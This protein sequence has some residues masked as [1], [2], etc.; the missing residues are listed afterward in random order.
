MRTA[1]ITVDPAATK[2]STFRNYCDLIRLFQS[3]GLFKKSSVVA[4]IHPSL[5]PTPISWYQK[6]KTKLAKDALESLQNSCRGKFQF[7]AVKVLRSDTHDQES[8]VRQ[9]SNFGRAN[10][11]DVLVISSHNRKG[12]PYWVLGSFAETASLTSA[13][14]VLI[15]KPH[16]K[17]KDFS[18]EVRMVVCI[19]V[20]VPISQPDLN[21]ILSSARDANAHVDWVYIEPS[22]IPLLETLQQAKEKPEAEK[23]LGGLRSAAAKKGIKSSVKVLQEYTSIAHTL[24]DY[25]D[26]RKAWLTITLSTR[27][28]RARRLWLGSTGRQVLKLTKRPFLNL[29]WE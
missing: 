8:L 18:S 27:R 17:I 12:L 6:S 9:I 24:V 22:P 4:A 11:A 1:L 15:L 7:D 23:I 25:A 13:L 2:A 28:S 26:S 16:H 5:Y 3:K 20:G 14:P 29:R 21:W 19:D 10:D